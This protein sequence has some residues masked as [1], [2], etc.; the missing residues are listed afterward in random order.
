MGA[1]R[2]FLWQTNHLPRLGVRRPGV[3]ETSTADVPIHYQRRWHGLKRNHKRQRHDCRSAND[4][5]RSGFGFCGNGVLRNRAKVCANRG[6]GHRQSHGEEGLAESFRRPLAV[7]FF[8]AVG[9]VLTASIPG[10]LFSGMMGAWRLDG[11]RIT[12]LWITD[13]GRPLKVARRIGVRQQKG[14]HR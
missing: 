12:D 9:Y 1:W 5:H 7:W 11:I 8:G 4:H 2:R 3:Q 6:A 13:H 10:G 14:V